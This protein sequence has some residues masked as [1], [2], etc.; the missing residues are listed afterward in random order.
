MYPD[1][2]PQNVNRKIESLARQ[3]NSKQTDWV[4]CATLTAYNSKRLTFLRNDV[5]D[6]MKVDFYGFDVSIP[7][8]YHRVLS[9]TYADYMQFPPIEKRGTWHANAV[10]NPDVPYE[11]VI[12]QLKLNDIQR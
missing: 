2:S 3:H 7:R 9:T 5:T 11:E 12:R 4:T 8:N 1:S 10:F 6:L